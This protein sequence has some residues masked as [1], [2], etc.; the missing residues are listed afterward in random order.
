VRSHREVDPLRG[1]TQNEIVN[2]GQTGLQV[3][4]VGIGGIP[5]TRPTEDEAI[6]LVRRALDLGVTFI[7]TARGYGDSEERIGKAP[8]AVSGRR[9][10]VDFFGTF[11]L[12]PYDEATS[13][14]L[15]A[16]ARR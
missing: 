9:E 11:E 14:R 10:Q 7:D 5:L 16:I 12:D 15:I 1:A 3:S 13:D 2:L 8:A 4:R 6:K